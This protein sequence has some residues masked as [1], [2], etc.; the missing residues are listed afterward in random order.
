[1]RDDNDLL[2]LIGRAALEELTAE[3]CA[4]IR[5]AAAMSPEIRQA[6]LERI[7]LEEQLAATL[8][9]P[10]VSVDE[11][12]A[13]RRRIAESPLAGR[14]LAPVVLALLLAGVAAAIALRPRGPREEE[15]A[16]ATPDAAVGEAAD[17]ED[18]EPPAAAGAAA[19]L[20]MEKDP[21]DEAPADEA[22]G[23]PEAS[24]TAATTGDAGPPAAAEKPTAPPAA[25]LPWSA[26]LAPDAPEPAPDVLFRPLPLRQGIDRTALETWF[27]PLPGATPKFEAT[28][29]AQ[30][31]QL[32][33]MTGRFRLVPPLRE[34]VALRVL[35][36]NPQALRIV[37][38]SG[39]SAA[40]I[41]AEGPADSWRWCG[42][43]LSR[44]AADKPAAARW[45][46][47]TSDARGHRS[48][49][50][51]SNYV[52]FTGIL[53]LRFTEG[54]LV[55]SRGEVRLVEVPL[56]AAADEVLFEG[57]MTIGGI[58]LVR[59]V[60]PPPLPESPPAT[61]AWR[62]A[63]LAWE[64]PAITAVEK[65]AD[66]SVRLAQTEAA[67]KTPLIAT[68]NLPDPEF[69]PRELIVRLDDF[70]PG[71]GVV[72]GGPDGKQQIVCGFVA[73]TAG[74]PPDRQGNL[75]L[76]WSADK[77]PLTAGDP[78]NLGFAFAPR[79]VW[80]R[81]QVGDS[82]L[83][84]SWSGDGHHWARLRQYPQVWTAATGAAISSIGLFAGAHPG[85]S[86]TL[87]EVAVAELPAFA[88]LL[89]R[90][91]L[92]AVNAG[93]VPVTD[94]KRGDDWVAATLKQK[95][96]SV[97]K[98]RWLAAAAIRC[99]AM[100]RTNLTARL[101]SIVWRHARSLDLPLAEQIDL[102]DDIQRL[103]SGPMNQGNFLWGCIHTVVARDHADRGDVAGFRQAWLRMQQAAGDFSYLISF[104]EQVD[105]LGV[106]SRL[107]HRLLV[108][109]PTVALWAEVAR[110][111][112]YENNA[113]P[114]VAALAD[115]PEFG[116]PMN[117]K[118]PNKVYDAVQA[119]DSALVA[120]DWGDAR[121]AVSGLATAATHEDE[122]HGLAPDPRDGDRLVSL[123]LLMADALAG[124]PNFRASMLQEPAERGWLRVL[125]L[126]EDGDA[127]GLAKAAVEF[128]GTPA[129][130]EALKWLAL[131]ALS[132][133]D[134]TEARCQAE[135]GLQWAA[136]DA[137]DRLI[138]I[139]TM[140]ESLAGGP[141]TTV[142]QTTGMDAVPAADVAEVVAAAAANSGPPVQGPFPRAAL[143]AVKRLDLG[144]AAMQAVS[145]AIFPGSW[146]GPIA[147]RFVKFFQSPPLFCGRVDWAAEECS[148]TATPDRL[149]V[150]NRVQMV[151]VDPATGA[152]Q[153]RSLVGPKPG[154]LYSYGLLP[155]RAACDRQHAYVRRL[156]DG[157]SPTL[158]A[159][160][161]ADGTT[162]WEIPAA[163]GSAFVSDPVHLYG[164]L[165]VCES[166]SGQFDDD[167]LALLAIDPE[168]GSRRRRRVIGGLARGWKVLPPGQ[169]EGLRGPGDCQ[170]AVAQDRL[171]VVAG[172]T[173][174]ACDA[175]GRPVWLRRQPW[176]G[177]AA[178][179]WW[180]RQAQTP[181]LVHAGM[182]FVV[183]PGV[184]AVTA[185]D[186]RNGRLTW[187]V[188]LPG[189]RRL[190]GRAGDGEAARLVVETAQGIVSINPKSGDVQMLLEGR[191]GSGDVWLGIGPTRLMGTA[192]ATADGH[193]IVAVQRRQPEPNKP[194]VYVVKLLWIDVVSGGIVH[195]AELPA[196]AGNPTTPP[197]VGPLASTGGSLWLLSS[198]NPLDLR[199]SLWQLAP[200]APP[201]AP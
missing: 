114:L 169:G 181:P 115:R 157:P 123:P 159:V 10:R 33:T 71:T 20:A 168:T 194:D 28:Q 57:A 178:D 148:F 14:W 18:A 155:M 40:V 29:V 143:E 183:Q 43:V 190:V 105:P 165:W 141:V 103:N 78:K 95:P 99:L 174:L 192:L 24:A 126:R 163:T 120:G 83:T 102:C 171:Y 179:G 199:R 2:D 35:V 111:Q 31:T 25:A 130:S 26:A 94:A 62:P 189:V 80:M 88:R 84:I 142:P 51:W 166:K 158:A 151:A 73:P 5:A 113:S 93:L 98:N 46:A 52:P 36:S 154:F 9:R 70:T 127:A 185:L 175:A 38:W 162:A 91:L 72:L 128:Q 85:R 58:E 160:R 198:P 48:G 42:S 82:V 176:V 3:Q 200:Q 156:A 112:L 69:G 135:A 45:L 65:G 187:R 7:G 41:E 30:G 186:A 86:I 137:R 19:D 47:S 172:G 27:A 55:L 101:C 97:E 196:L 124:D 121:R 79:P 1:M 4:S 134:W 76:T 89:P 32:T 116:G 54:L 164:T 138:T 109:G 118:T 16:V 63:D 90:D 106:R 96:E 23:P 147:E 173:V 13:G 149:L 6:C 145:N 140:A 152:E 139:R 146:G 110:R 132:V 50:G 167:E 75:F 129:A 37:A 92:P 68:W 125:Q 182:L 56:P 122:L 144:P 136:P 87:G 117:I 66:G 53:E 177:A 153:W 44:P 180:W 8:G 150:N 59:S 100:G 188:P 22:P 67:P 21:A 131:R 64:G 34:G 81:F 12:L 133:G 17:V 197:W 119:F 108:T 74:G 184:Q 107:T 170:I 11:L 61:T 195:E 104:G 161:L 39:N 15:V 193:A 77:S 60:S 191:D 49:A 201:K